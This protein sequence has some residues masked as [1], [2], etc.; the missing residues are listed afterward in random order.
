ME[1]LSYLK[2]KDFLQA[3]DNDNNKNYWVKIEVLNADEYPI[4]SIEGRVLPGSVIN[5]KGSSS[6]SRTCNISFIAIDEDNDLI[7]V[8]NLLSINKKIRIFEGLKNNINNL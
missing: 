4:K 7:N 1:A 8:E 3:L 6:V 2:E 5:I